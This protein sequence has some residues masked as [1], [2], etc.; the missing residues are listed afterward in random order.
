AVPLLEKAGTQDDLARI[1]LQVGKRVPA[2]ETYAYSA[3]KAAL[4]HLTNVLAGNL[5][6]RNITFNTIAPG[7]FDTKM[8]AATLKT[9]SN[10]FKDI[11]PLGRI[12][13]PEDIAGTC[14]YLCS[15]AGAYTNGANISVDG[16]YLCSKPKL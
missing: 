3:S 6:Q 10:G 4:H 13:N 8:M 12:G 9:H 14:I 16:G 2:L 1:F 15:R 5:S 7:P 11:I